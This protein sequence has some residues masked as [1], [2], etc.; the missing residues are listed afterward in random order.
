MFTRKAFSQLNKRLEFGNK[1][2]EEMPSRGVQKYTIV[3][4]ELPP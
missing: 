3:C 1:K 2:D 4:Y